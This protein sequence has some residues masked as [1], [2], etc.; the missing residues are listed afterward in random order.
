RGV[1]VG[2]VGRTASATKAEPLMRR[3][4]IWWA[5]MP[6]P[7][8]R[9]PVVLASRDVAYAVRSR[10]TVVEIT[11]RIRG[12]ETEV[13]LGA[14][15]GLPRRCCA[16]ADNILTIDKSWLDERVGVLSPDKM[17]RFDRALSLALGL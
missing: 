2:A 10:V 9:R 3:G 4:E 6:V 14:R 5:K 7:S 12:I 17:R 1:R 11:T 15:D 16:N 8:G 13:P